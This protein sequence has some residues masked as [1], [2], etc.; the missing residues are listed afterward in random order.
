MIFDD[1]GFPSCPGARKAVDEFF[2][3]KPETPIVLGTG[4]ALIVRMPGPS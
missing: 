3:G 2:G 4:Q 1:Y